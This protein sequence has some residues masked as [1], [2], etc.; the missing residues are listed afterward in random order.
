MDKKLKLKID[1]MKDLMMELYRLAGKIDSVI[2]QIETENDYYN[3][4][5]D[6]HE[7]IYSFS[8]AQASYLRDIIRAEHYDQTFSKL[9]TTIKQIL[10]LKP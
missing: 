8:K 3:L 10:E 6:K 7:F 1:E 4:P 9:D 2:T 5:Y